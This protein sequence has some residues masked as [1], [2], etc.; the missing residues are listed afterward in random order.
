MA[1]EFRKLGRPKVVYNSANN[2]NPI[3]AQLVEDGAKIT[4]TSATITIYKPGSTTAVLAATAMTVSGTLLT[5]EVDTTTTSDFPVD[6]GYRADIAVT[7][8]GEVKQTLVVMFDVVKYL[9]NLGISH[10]QL[11]AMD[12][13]IEGH[14]WAGD[15]DLSELINACRDVIQTKIEGKVHDDGKLIENMIL[16]SSR[17]A[18]AARFYILYRFWQAK[19]DED[20]ADDYRR[21]WEEM[22]PAVLSTIAYDTDQDGQESEEIGGIQEIRL[23]T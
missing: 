14:L 21:E 20:R 2:E 3:V 10:D 15:S 17:V 5:Y 4:P 8:S 22:W 19:G 12:A 7:V 11:L 6:T 1:Y 16:D 18:T 23:V 9:L 13:T